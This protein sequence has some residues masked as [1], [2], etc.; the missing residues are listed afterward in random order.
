MEALVAQ[1]T[2]DEIEPLEDV[3]CKF[4]CGLRVKN[5]ETKQEDL[6]KRGEL[7]ISVDPTLS[8]CLKPVACSPAILER[9]SL[10]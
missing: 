1:A 3:L 7:I 2:T 5:K 4:F 10:S 9:L 6:P 8:N